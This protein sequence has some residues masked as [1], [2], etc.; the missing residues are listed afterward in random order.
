M[1][2]TKRIAVIGMATAGLAATALVTAPTASATSY[3]GCGWPR[4]CFYMTDSNWYNGSP[5]AAYQDV[6]TSYQ[7]LG[8]SSRGANWVYNSRNDDR[9]YLR[10]V[11]DSTG[12]TGYRC[13]PP[14]H[15]QQFP[16]GYTVTGIRIDTASTCP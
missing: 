1:K 16:S 6:T 8:T 3:N 14:N 4:V 10:Y 12:A 15:Y 2:T 9:A 11:Y 5:T 13:L 7:N